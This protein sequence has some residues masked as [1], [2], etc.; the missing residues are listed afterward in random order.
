MANET[1][2]QRLLL[3]A[4][5]LFEQTDDDAGLTMPDI[6]DTIQAQGVPAERKALYRDM[7]ALRLAGFDVRSRPGKPVQYFLANRPF[8][9]SELLLLLDAVQSSRFITK[10]QSDALVRKVRA[11]GSQRQAA[12][13]EKRMH[14][15]GRIKSKNESVFNNVDAVQQAMAAKRKISF[16]YVGY[17]CSMKVK[18]RHGGKPYELTPVQLIY[19]DGFYYLV[20]FSDKYEDFANYR[21][22][23]MR[24][25]RILEARATRHALIATF[26]ADEY[27]RRVF[28]MFSGSS[29]RAVL[30]VQEHAMNAVV[31]RFG[32]D[33]HVE[34]IGDGIARVSVTAAATPVFF[35]WVSQFAGQITIESPAG[36]RQ[37]YAEYLRGLLRDYQ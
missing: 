24:S 22:D 13:L 32:K 11:M 27:E 3:L 35:G 1:G 19:S 9:H 21:V 34:E 30:R 33:A 36:L 25:I 15:G 10:R 29:V 7:E 2:K 28:G 5:M 37:G 8:S 17:D 23:R 4:K 12:G 18:L 20:C 31:D 6:V 14:V 16:T 26:D